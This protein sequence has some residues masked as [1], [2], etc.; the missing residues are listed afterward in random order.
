MSHWSTLQHTALKTS[1]AKLNVK[2]TPNR[3]FA[4]PKSKVTGSQ[5]YVAIPQLSISFYLPS[6]FQDLV[7]ITKNL[8]GE[9]GKPNTAAYFSTSSLIQIDSGCSAGA[10]PLGALVKMSGTYPVKSLDPIQNYGILVKQFNS[11]YI[12]AAYQQ[13][14]CAHNS[15]DGANSLAE[16]E[17]P[18]FLNAVHATIRSTD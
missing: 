5:I 8:P 12:S 13:K 2:A 10:A 17:A 6:S 15:L 7:Y 9:N 4:I 16:N 14:K 3:L 1:S 18:I 11:F